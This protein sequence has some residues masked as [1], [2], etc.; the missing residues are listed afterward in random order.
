MRG[1][2]NAVNIF[3]AFYFTDVQYNRSIMCCELHCKNP[4]KRT[5]RENE[6]H[7]EKKSLFKQLT[8]L[9]CI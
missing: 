7:Q 8:W 4:F 1:D 6:F 9:E 3:S 2:I 5:T